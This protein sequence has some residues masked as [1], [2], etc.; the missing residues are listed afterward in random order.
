[1]ASV[2]RRTRNGITRFRAMWREGNCLRSK[3]FAKSSD[4]KAFAS[5]VEQEV[6]RQGVADVERHTVARYLARWLATLRQRERSSHLD[7]AYADLRRAGDR[8]RLGK[9]SR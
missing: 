4:A 7:A 2:Q 6:E 9:T 8:T 5:R 3:T 1:M